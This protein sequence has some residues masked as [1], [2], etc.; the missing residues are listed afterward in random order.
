MIKPKPVQAPVEGGF[1]ADDF[2]VDE[3]AGTVTC[4]AGVT[5][6]ISPARHVVSGAAC[7]ACPLHHLQVRPG[8]EPDPARSAAARRP[9][10]LGC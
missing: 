2:A 4:P 10:G 6:T 3:Q 7:R 8:P 9:R 1:T 5:R